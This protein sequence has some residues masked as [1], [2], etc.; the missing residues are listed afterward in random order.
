MALRNVKLKDDFFAKLGQG[1]EMQRLVLAKAEE[2]KAIAEAISEDFR[3]DR[4]DPDHVH[5]A[6]SFETSVE[7]RYVGEAEAPRVSGR[8]TNTAPHAAA[9]EWGYKGRSD[10]ETSEAHRVLGRTL[11]ALTGSDE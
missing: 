2:A 3:S 1:P 4:D 11:A 6:D 8:L 5:Y 7:Q 10:A 9:V